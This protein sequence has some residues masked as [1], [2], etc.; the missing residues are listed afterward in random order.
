[1]PTPMARNNKI[2]LNLRSQF[3]EIQRKL[4]KILTNFQEPIILYKNYIQQKI[5]RRR[6][7]NNLSRAGTVNLIRGKG[8][9]STSQSCTVKSGSGFG[10]NHDGEEIKGVDEGL[11]VHGKKEVE[12]R[13]ENVWG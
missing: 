9:Q 13:F 6:R 10:W 7:K 12:A 11:K 3:I 8:S 2:V 4:R 1:M 5:K